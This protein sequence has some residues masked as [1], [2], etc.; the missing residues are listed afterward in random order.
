[1]TQKNQNSK[2]A[3]VNISLTGDIALQLEKNKAAIEKRL[4]IPV[5]IAFVVKLAIREQALLEQAD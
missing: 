4:G 1:M 3:R 5:T 2:D